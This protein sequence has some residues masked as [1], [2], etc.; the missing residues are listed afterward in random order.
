MKKLQRFP[1]DSG[2]AKFRAGK[3]VTFGHCTNPRGWGCLESK[4]DALPGVETA[5]AVPWYFPRGY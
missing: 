1:E 4:G 3:G 2:L 5:G